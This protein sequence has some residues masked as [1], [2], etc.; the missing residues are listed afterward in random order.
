MINNATS[1]INKIIK[2]GHVCQ[3]GKRYVK[4][5]P[6]DMSTLIKVAKGWPEYFYEHASEVIWTLREYL[7]EE[8]LQ[9]MLNNNIFIDT[10]LEEG[11][12]IGNETAAYFL[13]TTNG[14]LHIRPGAVTKLYLF[15]NAVLYIKPGQNSIISVECWNNTRV[16]IDQE[17]TAKAEV[18]LYDLAQATGDANIINKEYKRGEIFNGKEI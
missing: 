8:E 2:S 16:I 6:K 4:G 14:I 15:N 13:G 10:N 11:Q 12:E 3:T 9:Q 18:Y 17:P 5:T 7:K 1:I